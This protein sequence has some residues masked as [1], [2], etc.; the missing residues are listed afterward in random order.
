MADL[1]PTPW[2]ADELV[3]ELLDNES[4]FF[5]IPDQVAEASN[6]DVASN[7]SPVYNRLM[8]AVYSGPTMQDIESALSVTKYRNQ[9]EHVSQARVS[10]V[11]RDLSR[12]HE[13]NYRY[14]LRIKSCDNALA[15]DGYK[16]RKYGQKSIKN[17]PNPRSYYRCTNPRCGAKKQVERC[18][19][20]PE[21]LIITYEGLH[22]HFAYPFFPRNLPQQQHV[23]SPAKKKQRKPTSSSNSQGRNDQEAQRSFTTSINDAEESSDNVT[24]SSPVIP[25]PPATVGD[26]NT[27]WEHKGTEGDYS[28]QGLLEDVVP[29][30][31]RNPLI[32]P[33]SVNSSSSSSFPSTPTSPSSIS[34]PP[35]YS[36][37]GF[38][39]F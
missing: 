8:S 36:T 34:W 2:S 20:D 18:S 6:L 10:M 16:W 19:G 3:G 24:Y 23:N 9:T 31:I 39:G 38:V 1:Q 26:V 14:T 7:H 11:E 13:N 33:T 30:P 17:S 29:L 5:I 21:T 25:P 37:L 27:G 4:P 12:T 28:P 32:N 15:D 22:L 35:G